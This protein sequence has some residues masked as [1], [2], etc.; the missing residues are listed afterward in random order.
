MCRLIPYSI[1]LST[2]IA[3]IL[4]IFSIDIPYFWVIYYGIVIFHLCRYL[5]QIKKEQNLPA[6]VEKTETLP[7]DIH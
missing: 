2:V 3:I 7:E 1:T 4:N 5:S 6:P